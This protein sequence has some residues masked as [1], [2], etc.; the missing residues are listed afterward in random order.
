MEKIYYRIDELTD[1]L[2]IGK[3]TIWKLMA[4]DE[5]PK[6]IKISSGIK[7]WKKEDILDWVDEQQAK[8]KR[9]ISA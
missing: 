8:S 3:S 6:S 1:I 4:K 7:C 5:F 9:D 2:S